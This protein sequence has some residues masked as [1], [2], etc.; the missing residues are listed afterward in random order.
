MISLTG[1]A[2]G[3]LAVA[4]G[5]MAVAAAAQSPAAFP[6]KTVRIVVPN[7]PGG[8]VD[9]IARV[10]AAFLEPRFKQSFIVENRPGANGQIATEQVVRS[11]GDPHTLI[12]DSP[13]FLMNEGALPTWPFRLDRDLTPITVIAGTG[14]AIVAANKTPYN[15]LKE[16]VAYSRANPG[17]VNEAQAGTFNLDMA[18]LRRDLGMGAVEPIIYP[19]AAPII[20]ALVAGDVDTSGLVVQ[21]ATAWEKAKKV[22]ILAQTGLTRHPQL[23][24]IP[25]VSE[26]DVGLR[27]H[28]TAYWVALIG[29]ANIPAEVVSAL[30]NA[31]AELPKSAEA[32]AKVTALGQVFFMLPPAESRT[33]MRTELKRYQDAAASGM[34]VQ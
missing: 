27:N 13:K 25:T 19:G 2:R 5:L 34:R 15:T 11:A 4:V 14:Y 18:I 21:A 8:P 24:H 6:N 30:Y 20:T 10:T 3:S 17:K 33:R 29:P 28:E 7:T 16:L 31:M 26:S 12:V 9:A 32:A 22:K 23:P 1:L